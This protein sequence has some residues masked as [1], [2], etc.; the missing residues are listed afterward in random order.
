MEDVL[1][2][3]DDEVKVEKSNVEKMEKHRDPESQVLEPQPAGRGLFTISVS[4]H[5]QLQSVSQLF[6]LRHLNGNINCNVII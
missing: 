2:D 3:D 4:T 1:D 5:R 6:L